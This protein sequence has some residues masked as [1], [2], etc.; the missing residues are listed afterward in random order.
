MQSL[1]GFL[2]L[3]DSGWAPLQFTHWA[4]FYDVLEQRQA[5]SDLAP[6]VSDE[7]RN[8]EIFGLTSP[9]DGRERQES[10][11]FIGKSLKKH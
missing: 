8:A 3:Y 6:W 5:S 1:S 11:V 4:Y 2:L 10:F 9:E 7:L